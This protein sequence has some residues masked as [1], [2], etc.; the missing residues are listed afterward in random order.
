MRAPRP[1]HAGLG[2]ARMRTSVRR[3][4]RTLRR[5]KRRD[6]VAR[7]RFRNPVGQNGDDGGASALASPAALAQGGPRP[8]SIRTGVSA[9]FATSFRFAQRVEPPM[10]KSRVFAA[11]VA[12][13]LLTF[14]THALADIFV[15]IKQCPPGKVEKLIPGKN[16]LPIRVCV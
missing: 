15:P 14:A 12:A 5:A 10:S 8:E 7:L 16:G 6:G 9:A 4:M 13:G 2:S 11:L 3:R 1:A